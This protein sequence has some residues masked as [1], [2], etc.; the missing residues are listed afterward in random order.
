MQTNQTTGTERIQINKS[1]P[2]NKVSP[3]NGDYVAYTERVFPLPEAL[4]TLQ[5]WGVSSADFSNHIQQTDSG[6]Q[7]NRRARR[8]K[9]STLEWDVIEAKGR[10]IFVV[11][12]SS[13]SIPLI[14][15]VR[16][17]NTAYE[18]C[19][20]KTED[21]SSKDK[22][23]SKFDEQSAGVS[24]YHSY[25][26]HLCIVDSD[27]SDVASFVASIADT[28]IVYTTQSQG[29]EDVSAIMTSFPT[30][31]QVASGE[32]ILLVSAEARPVPCTIKYLRSTVEAA[33]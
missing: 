9:L 6:W 25:D 29:P 27:Y 17:S 10:H 18:T 2:N 21:W 12:S 5:D 1:Q 33:L 31:F 14:S 30:N 32:T 24:Y 16:C 28:E 26:T 4:T 19:N 3:T 22:I 8:A 20:M 15:S 7:Y 23:I 11:K 13:P